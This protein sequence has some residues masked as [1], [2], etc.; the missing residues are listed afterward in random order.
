MFRIT[1]L[2][3][4]ELTIGWLGSGLSRAAPAGAAVDHLVGV[5]GGRNDRLAVRPPHIELA[6]VLGNGTGHLEHR[7]LVRA[8]HLAERA[9]GIDHA[10]VGLVLQA[11]LL[12]VVPK[13][14]G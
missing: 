3:L 10:L 7:D 13:F 8:G 9:V 6:H 11:V 12:D 2:P 4:I 14:L 5:V 1:L